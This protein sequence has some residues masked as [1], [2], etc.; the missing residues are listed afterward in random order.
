[1]V[2]VLVF[3]TVATLLTVEYIVKH[4][5]AE[6]VPVTGEGL[7]FAAGPSPALPPSLLSIP[8]NIYLARAHT[9][10]RPESERTFRVGCGRLPVF[11]LGRPDGLELPSVGLTVR[12]GEPIATL[13]RG[14]RRLTLRSPADGVVESVNRDAANR[15]EKISDQPFG[16]GWLCTIRP[17]NVAGSLR[18]LLVAEEATGWMR[19]E[20]ARLRDTISTLSRPRQVV[21]LMTDGGLPLEGFASRLDDEGWQQVQQRFFDHPPAV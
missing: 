4:R 7:A 14:N 17:R 2:V 12:A 9:W 5:Q 6:R 13:R 15:P 20:I 21:P 1:M 3:L 11:A 19:S 8:T 16:D 10:V 18:R